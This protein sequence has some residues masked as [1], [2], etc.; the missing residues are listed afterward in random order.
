MNRTGGPAPRRLR[1]AE[2]IGLVALWL[3]AAALRAVAWLRVGAISND[4]PRYLEQ[5]QAFGRGDWV[6]VLSEAYHPLYALAIWLV[7][8]AGTFT[9]GAA[10]GNPRPA[11]WGVLPLDSAPA[12]LASAVS[13]DPSWEH[14]AVLVSITAGATAAVLLMRLLRE[15][16]GAPVGWVGGILLAVHSRAVEFSAEV[17]SDP[18]YL[19]LFVLALWWGWRALRDR[20][21]AAAAVLGA[22]SGVA[23]LV[24]PEGLVVPTAAAAVV[25]LSVLRGF[26]PR[27]AALVWLACAGGTTLLCVLP[28][29]FA[30]R[31]AS[32]GWTLSQ[33]KSI[34][35]FLAGGA[36]LPMG[37]QLL[38]TDGNPRWIS[39]APLAP[40]LPVSPTPHPARIAAAGADLF[41]TSLSSLR[42]VVLLLLGVG[43]AASLGRP[44]LRAIWSVAPLAV[45]LPL[46][47]LLSLQVGYVSRRH[48]LPPLLPL[49]GYAAEGANALGRAIC[50]ALRRATKGSW[51]A[52]TRWGFSGAIAPCVGTAL[53]VALIAPQHFQIE[54]SSHVASRRAAEWLRDHAAPAAAAN[55]LVAVE[56]VRNGYYSGLPAVLIGGAE[57][58]H[59]PGLLQERAIRYAI[60]D[61]ARYAAALL[62]D[63]R[64]RSLSSH[65]AFGHTAR[66]F[67]RMPSP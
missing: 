31:A 66:V 67:G 34:T 35:K 10:T 27:R 65:R 11:G 39:L 36:D 25:A 48:T 24:R 12:P 49:F 14:A 3:G 38:D 1:R 58:E 41:D 23:Y 37:R 64:F 57:P 32:G 47:F 29:V 55:S 21:P 56:T 50:A 19:A 26:W 20:S 44:G 43:V 8:S 42:P 13:W 62:A 15:M 46:L 33:K 53:A 22:A 9:A 2:R 16:F 28:Y 51:Q 45:A 59:L 52:A 18:L 61:E 54:R 4:G 5:A 17:Q 6:G 40:P 30:L 7:R 63:P 60:V